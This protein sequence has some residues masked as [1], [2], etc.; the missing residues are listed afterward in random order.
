MVQSRVSV[1]VDTDGIISC[2]V[3]ACEELKELRDAKEISTAICSVDV[4]RYYHTQARI[5]TN[6]MRKSNLQLRLIQL[7][8]A[9]EKIFVELLQNWI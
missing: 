7:C 4:F 6:L 9:V 8:E 5:F 2:L 3:A 1:D